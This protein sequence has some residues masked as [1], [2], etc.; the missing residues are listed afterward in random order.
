[1]ICQNIVVGIS[2]GQ[3]F[4]PAMLLPHI[5]ICIT[6]MCALIVL[7]M[8]IRAVSRLILKPLWLD[9]LAEQLTQKVPK[10]VHADRIVHTEDVI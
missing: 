8:I 6:A 2:E 10:R 4:Y 3:Y 1:M 9:Q 5:G 7:S